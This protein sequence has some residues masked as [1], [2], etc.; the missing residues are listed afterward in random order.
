MELSLLVKN[1]LKE[2]IAAWK[3]NIWLMLI[4]KHQNCSADMFS[5]CLF[6]YVVKS[7]V[8]LCSG[9]VFVVRNRWSLGSH[10]LSVSH[11]HTRARAHERVYSW[12]FYISKLGFH[13]FLDFVSVY[14]P[15]YYGDLLWS[16]PPLLRTKTMAWFLLTVWCGINL[17]N[18]FHR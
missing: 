2:R 17:L 9:S 6:E 18:N 7:C 1:E 16:L 11:T 15:Y 10:W 14:I 3:T 4:G 5:P 8:I 13:H 12:F